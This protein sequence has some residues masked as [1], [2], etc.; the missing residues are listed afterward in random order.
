MQRDAISTLPPPTCSPAKILAAQVRANHLLHFHARI[1]RARDTQGLYDTYLSTL[2]PAD[3]AVWG[4]AAKEGYPKY[5]HV[6]TLWSGYIK[7]G[8]DALVVSQPIPTPRLITPEIEA[9]LLS[10]LYHPDPARRRPNL[11]NQEL[12]RYLSATMSCPPHAVTIGRWRK[13]WLSNN[14]S[15]ALSLSD[16]DA[17]LEQQHSRGDW[18]K[19]DTL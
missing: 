15:L 7:D 14:A 11:S 13:A 5:S 17:Q 19:S 1:G 9:Q 16:P 3:S 2:P 18:V 6:K 8:L 12:H 10:V 4:R